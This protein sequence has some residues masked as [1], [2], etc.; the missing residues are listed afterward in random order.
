MITASIVLLFLVVSLILLFMINRLDTENIFL[1]ISEVAVIPI[2]G[3]FPWLIDKGSSGA[4]RKIAMRLIGGVPG[5]SYS[6]I[7]GGEI[8]AIVSNPVIG[9]GLFLGLFLLG[10]ILGILLGP[11]IGRWIAKVLRINA[12]IP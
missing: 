12:E 4:N 8:R 7:V 10:G 6:F 1:L 9:V 5:M 3:V 2:I 11:I